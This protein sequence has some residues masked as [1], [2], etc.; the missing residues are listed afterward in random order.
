MAVVLF[1]QSVRSL[2][3][4][5]GRTTLSAVG[6][7][8][9]IAAVVWVVAIGIAG[10]E[11]AAA[12]LQD[13]GDNLVWVEAGSRNVAG[14]RTGSKSTST[15]TL[16]DAE[17]ILREVP[18][19]QSVSPQVDGNVQ[20]VSAQSNW[21]TRSRGIAPAYVAIK[22][23]SIAAGALFNDEDVQLGR[24][25][26]VMGQ[27]VRQRLFGADNP[28]GQIV[29]MNGQPFEVVGLL[30]PK[31]QSATGTDQ[32]DVVMVPYSTANRKLRPAGQTWLDD[33]V[34][35]AARPDLI[36]ATTAQIT[37][38]VRERHRIAPGQDDDFN[39]RHPEEVVKAQMAASE[40]FSTLLLVIASVALL[41][42]GIG[43]MNVMLASVSE[44]RREIGVRLAIG[45]KPRSIVLQ[46][47]VEAVLVSLFGGGLGLAASLAGSSILEHAVGWSLRIPIESFVVAF[48]FSALVGVLFGYL[49][50]RLAS[51]LDPVEALS[52]D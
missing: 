7:A 19:V 34:C 22:R 40:T 6:I 9:A 38:L 26:L 5:R 13:L 14:V 45:A 30:A 21:S 24:N 16:G 28:V 2:A 8:I 25:V 32:D 47:L 4:H 27:T 15:L 1:G 39:I 29:R 3:R 36:E 46:F 41:V 10:A 18:Y 43:I 11:R 23:F 31:G 49:P 33:I 44:R 52:S 50:A 17:A 35:S 12:L 37:A 51:R 20:I 48:A 42:G